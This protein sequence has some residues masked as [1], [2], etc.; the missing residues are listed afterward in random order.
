MPGNL[1]VLLGDAARA[2][3]T[4]QLNVILSRFRQYREQHATAII[5]RHFQRGIGGFGFTPYAPP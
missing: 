3:D 2:L 5:F 4:T 1:E